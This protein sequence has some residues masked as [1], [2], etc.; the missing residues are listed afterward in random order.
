MLSSNSFE[1]VLYESVV[2]SAAK[3][4]TLDDKFLRVRSYFSHWDHLLL[5]VTLSTTN[6]WEVTFQINSREF[7][8]E[9]KNV[10][11]NVENF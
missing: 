2:S 4:K 5:K 11:F 9:K 8:S 1:N 6:Y 10:L 7:Y 3:D